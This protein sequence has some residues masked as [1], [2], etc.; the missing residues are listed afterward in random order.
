MKMKTRYLLFFLMIVLFACKKTATQSDTNTYQP[1]FIDHFIDDWACAVNPGTGANFDVAE[2]RLWIPDTIDVPKVKAILVLAEGSNS[3]A[4]NMTISNDWRAYAIANK[5]AL[6]GVHL[7]SKSS[8]TVFDNYANAS[9]GS[10]EALIKALEA[11]TTHNHVPHIAALP[12]LLRGY[13]AGGMFSYF[14][15]DY[16]PKRVIAFADIRGWII[17]QNASETKYIPGLFLIGELDMP[18]SSQRDMM[19]QIVQSKR[20][21]DGLWSYAIEPDADHFAGLAASDSLIKLFFSSALTYRL[22][23]ASNDLLTIA[24][25]SGWLGNT[26]TKSIFPYATY[27]EEKEKAGWLIDES[28]AKAWKEFQKK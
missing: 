28:F 10:G 23:T 25:A 13:S 5:I 15:S 17:N 26:D 14:F 8:Q 22:S 1:V 12:F 21:Q 20:K 4:T 19:Q 6:M 18:L 16:Q 9:G 7:E 3:N 24:P 27:P 11:I 2:F